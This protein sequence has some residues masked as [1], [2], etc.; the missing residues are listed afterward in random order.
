M[1]CCLY[2]EHETAIVE[3]EK[4]QLQEKQQL[5]DKQLKEKFILQRQLLMTRQAKVSYLCGSVFMTVH[6][7][8]INSR[9]IYTVG[10][11]LVVGFC[12]IKLNTLVC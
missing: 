3:L 2:L 11:I 6:C 10:R 5:E 12:W 8:T 1:G 4:R 7:I 9:R